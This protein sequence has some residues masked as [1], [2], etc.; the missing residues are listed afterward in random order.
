MADA[1]IANQFPMRVSVDMKLP[2]IDLPAEVHVEVLGEFIVC[3]TCGSF[4]PLCFYLSTPFA[5]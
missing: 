3:Q 5:K 2:M 4:N 1:T